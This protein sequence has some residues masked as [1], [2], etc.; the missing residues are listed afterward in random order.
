MSAAKGEFHATLQQVE[1]HLFKAVYSG[2]INPEDPDESEIPDSHI[3]TSP[4]D[5]KTW[6]EQMALSMGYTSVVWDELPPE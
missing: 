5:V 1:P 3:G 4:A 6:V 2:E